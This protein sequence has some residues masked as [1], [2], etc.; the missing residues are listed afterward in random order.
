[1]L[2]R[3]LISHGDA[4]HIGGA[5]AILDAFPDALVVGQ[6]IESLNAKNKQFCQQNMAWQWDDVS[7]VFLS[8]DMSNSAFKAGK[9]NNRSCV[10]QV[11]SRYGSALLTGDIE[12][13]TERALVNNYADYLT[14]NILVV[15]HHGSNTSSNIDFIRAVNPK[16]SL[17]SAG[18]KNR[19]KLPSSKVVARYVSENRNFLTTSKEGAMTVLI[20]KAH[21][22]MIERYREKVARYWHYNEEQQRVA[23]NR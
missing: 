21:S 8:P 6:D 4:D 11:N 2:D 9:R 12:K 15:P 14:S 13:S 5:Q 23:I 16:I 1:M 18:Y 19:Y 10:L 17:I 7:F 3:L 20:T 22:L